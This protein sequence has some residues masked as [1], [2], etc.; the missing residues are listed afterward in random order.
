MAGK[1]SE[2]RTSAPANTITGTELVEVTQGGSSKAATVAELLL[3]MWAG[4]TQGAILYRAATG[5]SYL[6]AGTAGYLL[7]TGGAS[8]APTWVAPTAAGGSGTVTSVALSLPSELTVSGSPI[9]TSGTLSAAWASQAAGKVF[10]APPGSAGTPSFRAL[11]SSDLPTHTHTIS[12]VTGLSAALA[13]KAGTATATTSSDG[14]MSSAD[15]AKLNGIPAGGGTGSASVGVNNQSASA[16]TLTATD[17]GK[18]VRITGSSA[19]A[20]TVPAGVFAV[21]DVI[22]VRQVGAG[23]I[24]ASGGTLNIPAGQLAK[25]RTQGSVM[26]L[27]CVASGEFD[28]SGDLA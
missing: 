22:T 25:T 13:D 15:K 21:G 27:H 14:L 9:N 17:A 6:P 8:A 4:T 2:L 3:A 16:Y 19:I 12:D 7:S 20:L 10:A 28:I 23:Q 1:L 5:W 18:V 26:T 24:T 11:T